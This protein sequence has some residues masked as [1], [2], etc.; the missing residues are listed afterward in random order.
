MMALKS[1]K[2]GVY[3]RN[4]LAPGTPVPRN[5]VYFAMPCLAGQLSS[6]E[7][8]EGI[9]AAEGISEDHPL[10]REALQ[11]PHDADKQVLFT[12]IHT[13]KGM[14]NEARIALPLEFD[15]EFSHHHGLRNFAK[16]GAII[17]NCV[18]RSYCKKLVVLM[19]GQWHPVHYHKRKEETFQVLF[20]VTEMVVE[21]RRRTL[22]P[23]DLQLVQQGV[24][25]EFWSE[26]GTIFEELST[27]HF[28]DDS[29]YEDKAIN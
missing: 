25:H 11:V 5:D 6:G 2:R 14:L 24:W 17:I 13:A 12:A 4:A 26:G 19:P 9:E 21:G 29:F 28:D 7:W 27:K 10:M 8:K 15:V 3:A 23:G 16:V 22:Y 1:L 20:G 18:N